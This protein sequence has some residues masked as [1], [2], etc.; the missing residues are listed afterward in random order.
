VS[1]WERNFETVLTEPLPSI[2]YIRDNTEGK[3][4]FSPVLHA[5]LWRIVLGTTLPL[6]NALQMEIAVELIQAS[7]VTIR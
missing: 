7:V 5:Y 3:N 4:A 2:G 1:Y 6:N